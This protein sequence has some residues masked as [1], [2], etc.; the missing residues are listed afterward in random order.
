[1]VNA[2]RLFALAFLAALACPVPTGTP[3]AAHAQAPAFVSTAGELGP[4]VDAARAVG[5]GSPAPDVVASVPVSLFAY[6]KP[7]GDDPITNLA[8]DT[9]EAARSFYFTDARDRMMTLAVTCWE[10]R[11]ASVSLQGFLDG[12]IAGETGRS[13]VMGAFGVPAGS[14]TPDEDGTVHWTDGADA[15][16]LSLPQG[17]R[18]FHYQRRRPAA[19]AAYRV[20]YEEG[21]RT[22]KD[23]DEAR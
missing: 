2:A 1:M 18:S 23:L 7:E 4:Y 3:G 15:V 22:S 8:G 13:A 11:V 5:T 20:W 19:Y 10:G 12:A 21:F 9:L 17:A 14:A 16:S 6:R